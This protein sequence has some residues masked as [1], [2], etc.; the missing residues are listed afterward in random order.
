MRIH[1]AKQQREAVK[2]ATKNQLNPIFEVWI[3]FLKLCFSN[4]VHGLLLM[5]VEINS[6][7][8]LLLGP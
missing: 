6:G 4:S 2:R 5:V 1:G 8:V 7:I 3:F